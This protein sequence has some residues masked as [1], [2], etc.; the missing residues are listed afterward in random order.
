MSGASSDQITKLLNRWNQGDG[1]ARDE[2]IPLVYSELRR[3]ARRRLNGGRD[4]TLQSAAL[5]HEVYL[6]LVNSPSV[7][8]RDRVHFFAVAAKI[9]RRILV[10]YARRQYAAKRG[11][12]PMTLTLEEAVALPNKTEVN[13]LALDDALTDLAAL[14]PRQSQIVELRY[15]GGLSIEETSEALNVSP[16]TVKREWVTARTWLYKE[17]NR[18]AA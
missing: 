13:L 6:R 4:H 10:D 7:N 11:A 16:A 3:L 18:A 12:S 14:D 17:M 8:W 1:Q 9:M 15:F 2:L 5:V